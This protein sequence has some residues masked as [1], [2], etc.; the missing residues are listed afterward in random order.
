MASSA[1]RSVIGS[2][3]RTGSCLGF[4]S[5][6]AAAGTSTPK[7][8]NVLKERKHDSIDREPTRTRTRRPVNVL[9]ERWRGD[10]TIS[11]RLT[12]VEDKSCCAQGPVWLKDSGGA[13]VAA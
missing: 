6:A 4:F 12:P 11:S 1:V 5:V 9:F 8:R 7:E 2:P 10:S 3:L 13:Q